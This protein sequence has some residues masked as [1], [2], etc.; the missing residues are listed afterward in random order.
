[1]RPMIAV[2]DISLGILMGVSLF[3]LILS[4]TSYRRSGTS[5]MLLA[6]IGFV[7]HSTLTIYI[8][9]AGH[10]TDVM[11]NVDGVQLVALD[12]SVLVVALLIGVLGGK[13]FAR[14]S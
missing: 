6:S 12:V 7:A 5:Q 8:L 4:V 11:A 2:V 3:L 1:M 10:L 13:A 14:P 9:V